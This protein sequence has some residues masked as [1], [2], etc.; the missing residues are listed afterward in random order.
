MTRIEDLV[1]DSLRQRAEDVEPTPALWREVDRRIAR[2]RR[3]QVTSWSMAAVA[4]AL[5]AFVVLPGLFGGNGP[6]TLDIDYLG[7]RAQGVVPDVAVIVDGDGLALVEL[8]TGEQTGLGVPVD[9]PVAHLAV[10]PGSTTDDFDLAVVHTPDGAGATTTFVYG[11][12]ETGVSSTSEELGTLDV[13]PTIHW[14]PN[15][16][17]IAYTEPGEGGRVRLLVAP[18]PDVPDFTE[19]GQ[20][21]DALDG[22]PSPAAATEVGTLGPDDV[23]LDWVL[24]EQEGLSELWVRQA[25]G[26]V[27]ILPLQADGS[28]FDAVTAGQLSVPDAWGGVMDQARVRDVTVAVSGT[29]G[30][31]TGRPSLYL[32][33]PATTDGVSLYWSGPVAAT[34]TSPVTEVPLDDL[35][36]DAGPD[37]VWLDAER[38]AVLLGD[39]RQV[40]LFAHDGQGDFA[41]PVELPGVTA[42]A[43]FDAPRTGPGDEDPT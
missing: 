28:T 24:T 12:V 41:P 38:D 4:A 21:S 32:L 14:S 30:A 42:A 36:G 26:T 31:S 35:V 40:W 19:T 23:L 33:A 37:E 3:F 20:D 13:V 8:G 5:A 17:H 6:G 39:G 16:D 43:L 10:R 27:G 18:A 7:P 25:D 34:D 29:P 15:G 22:F 9:G 2:R 1:S 11:R